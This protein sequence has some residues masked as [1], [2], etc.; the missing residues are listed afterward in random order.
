[1]EMGKKKTTVLARALTLISN[2][3]LNV[4]FIISILSSL[5][6]NLS[7]VCEFSRNITKRKVCHIFFHYHLFSF[8]MQTQISGRRV[9]SDGF[10]C[11]SGHFF[12]VILWY[13]QQSLY[14]TVAM[15]VLFT[16]QYERMLNICLSFIVAAPDEDDDGV[17][18]CVCVC[19]L[20]ESTNYMRHKRRSYP[21]I[22]CGIVSTS[23]L[24]DIFQY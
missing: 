10:V 8:R 14:T 9:L 16:I 13:F 21:Q 2:S 3:A 4:D 7:I 17:L 23:K 24:A 20:N 22:Y 11:V 5:P 12:S 1:M 6:A 15:A 19:V 18:L